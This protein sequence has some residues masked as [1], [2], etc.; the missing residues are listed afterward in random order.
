MCVHNGETWL[1]EAVESILGQSLSD[2]EF[3]VVDDGSTDGSADILRSYDA[4][5]IRVIHQEN[6]GLA[7][8]RNTG[9]LAATGDYVA[10]MDADDVSEPRRLEMQ[11]GF[12]D[13]HRETV[14]VG[15]SVCV[16]DEHGRAI[17]R[18]T[19]ATGRERCR[20]RLLNGRFYSY[21]SALVVRREAVLE[22]GLFRTFFRQREDQDLM[23]RL[24]ERGNLDN[25]E[26]VLYRYRINPVGLTHHDLRIGAYYRDLAF[27]FFQ[28]RQ[29]TGSDRLQRGEPVG[30]FAPDSGAPAVQSS[31]RRVLAGLH[32]GEAELRIECGRPWS[33]AFHVLR[34][35]TLDPWRRS[36]VRHCW[37]ALRE[38]PSS[39]LVAP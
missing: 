30:P 38:R 24:V 33:A 11:C 9:T 39:V 23:L 14:G 25:V 21:G 17:F 29:A 13:A 27:A 36:T 35:L 20:Q 6:R 8:A 18:Q 22:V 12:L 34:A 19:A 28:E 26:D 16:T 32:L 31:L 4:P 7:G 2:F 5:G 10:Y 37:K 15:C 3:I 1:R